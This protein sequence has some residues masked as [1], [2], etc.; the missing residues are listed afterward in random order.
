MVDSW[1]HSLLFLAQASVPVVRTAFECLL[2]ACWVDSGTR[3]VS[4]L[5]KIM[6]WTLQHYGSY[7]IVYI[8]T[9]TVYMCTDYL[10]GLLENGIRRALME[11]LVEVIRHVSSVGAS[12]KSLVIQTELLHSL[13][14]WTRTKQV[15]EIDTPMV[16][17]LPDFCGIAAISFP[18]AVGAVSV[19]SSC[20]A[21]P[22][23]PDHTPL[24]RLGP[25]ARL[26]LS[27]RYPCPARKSIINR[28]KCRN[29]RTTYNILPY[30]LS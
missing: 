2:Q 30:Y 24:S 9:D 10:S 26:V 27:S 6:H 23:R 8:A 18:D 21:H 5:C 25:M 22:S 19:Y 4:N 1:L 11:T 3:G 17:L 28:A 20:I 7:T 29:A 14:A 12:Q 15:G 13:L 16:L